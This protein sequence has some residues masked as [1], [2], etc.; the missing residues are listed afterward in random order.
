MYY[1]TNTVCTCVVCHVQVLSNAIS[2]PVAPPA[3]PQPQPPAPVYQ[4]ATINT[5]YQQAN[6]QYEEEGTYR[7]VCLC[8][9]CVSHVALLGSDLINY[10][11]LLS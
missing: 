11:V 1:V 10:V 7:Y 8:A 3:P 5:V 9:F 4:Q 6:G 2:R